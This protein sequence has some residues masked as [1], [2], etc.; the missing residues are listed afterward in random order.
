MWHCHALDED[1][2]CTALAYELS[3]GCSLLCLTA[4]P[5]CCSTYEVATLCA[6]AIHADKLICLIDGPVVDAS[7]RLVRWM[8]L[9]Q[10]DLLIRERAQVSYT[11]G[12]YV[13][14]VAGAEY[15][16]SIGLPNG[17][18]AVVNGAGAGAKK[19]PAPAGAQSSELWVEEVGRQVAQ[20]QGQARAAENEE[21][22]AEASLARWNAQRAL[23]T[24]DFQKPK[25]LFSSASNGV[26]K[27]GNGASNGTGNGNGNRNGNGNGATRGLAV[28]GEERT[29]GAFGYLS[30]L[31]AAVFACRVNPHFLC[32]SSPVDPVA[33]IALHEPLSLLSL[34]GSACSYRGS[35]WSFVLE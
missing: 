27:A 11:A 29:S 4:V 32:I 22:E 15:A 25:P 20:E 28:G 23:Y 14:A 33:P 12:D 26:S 21:N 7:G 19:G 5:S 3:E 13:K 6:T 30:E 34:L 18:P 24:M 35:V 9:Q 31:T 17:T 8:T 16:K 2:I 10:A 1:G